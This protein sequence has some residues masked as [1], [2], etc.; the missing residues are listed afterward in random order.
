MVYLQFL[1]SRCWFPKLF[2]SS[3]FHIMLVLEVGSTDR[4]GGWW[5]KWNC[6]LFRSLRYLLILIKVAGLMNYLLSEKVA[7]FTVVMAG[8]A[9]GLWHAPI[10]SVGKRVCLICYCVYSY[11]VPWRWDRATKEKGAPWRRYFSSLEPAEVS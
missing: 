10:L 7:L 5:S 6:F 3:F 1:R 11:T 9:E 4:E 8:K 2:N